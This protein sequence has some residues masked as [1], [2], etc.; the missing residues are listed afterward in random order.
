MQKRPSDNSIRISRIIF[1][2]IM[3]S[4][5]YYNLIY[6]ANPN[7]LDSNFFWIDLSEQAIMIITYIIISLWLI[8]LFMW[9][10]NICLLKKNHMKIVQ[11]I[12][13]IC[14]FYISNQIVEWSEMDID[15][16][17]W[18]MWI[19][20]LFAGITGKCITSSCLKYN[21]KITKIRV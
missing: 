10:S 11:V 16:L 5:L 20:P 2:L 14:L 9:I 6:Q 7:T 8:P 19:A 13:A 15:T 21:E 18:F 4:T 1:G 17:I 3:V 12:F